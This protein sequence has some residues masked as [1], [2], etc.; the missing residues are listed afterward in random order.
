MN[1]QFLKDISFESPNVPELF[2]KNDNGQAKLE[3]NIDSNIIC[4]KPK[5]LNY[6][7]SMREKISNTLEIGIDSISIKA[8]TNEK[9]DS[10]G[11]EK[12]ISAQVVVLLQKNR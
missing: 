10:M 3:I 11:E 2:F 8:K 12:S 6:I 9:L 5:L 1:L 4:Q 7:D